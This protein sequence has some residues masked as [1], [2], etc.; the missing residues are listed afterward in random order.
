[1]VDDATCADY[2]AALLRGERPDV[3]P[4]LQRVRDS[5][6]GSRLADLARPELPAADLA[7]C[8]AVDHFDFA[9]RVRRREGLLVMEK[10]R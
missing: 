7:C 10:V 8:L 9:M 5:A 1:V 2:I 6:A 3:A 4:S